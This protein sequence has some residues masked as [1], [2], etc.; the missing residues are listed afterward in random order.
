[1]SLKK[2]ARIIANCPEKTPNLC[3]DD[4]NHPY[5]P[6]YLETLKEMIPIGTYD[7]KGTDYNKN[8]ELWGTL[9][10]S[11]DENR[12]LFDVDLQLDPDGVRIRR[13]GTV[14]ADSIDRVYYTSNTKTLDDAPFRATKQ[15]KCVSKDVDSVTFVGYGS[16]TSTGKYHCGTNVKKVFISTGSGAFRVETYLNDKLSYW[17]EYT[18]RKVM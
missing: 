16:S 14:N 17:V 8:V 13:E 4:I 18:R 12:M 11:H 6:D 7:M 1:M 2:L 3:V 5:D 15:M 9:N 10:V